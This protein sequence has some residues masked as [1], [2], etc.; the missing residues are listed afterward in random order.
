[1]AIACLTI[2][3]ARAASSLLGLSGI[4]G[5]TS[6]SGLY[7]SCVCGSYPGVVSSEPSARNCGVWTMPSRTGTCQTPSRASSVSPITF[8]QSL[9]TQSL[10]R[11]S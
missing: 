7:S 8:G 6:P 11:R 1:M 10:R 9:F 2:S 4:S 5:K 3:S